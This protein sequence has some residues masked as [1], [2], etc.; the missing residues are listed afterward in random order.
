[1]GAAGAA[2]GPLIGGA[3]L[4]HFWW[5]SVFL[6]NVPIMAVVIPVVFVLLPRVEHTTPGKWAVGQ[7]LVLIAGII[8]VVY[9]IKASIGATQS[10][11][12]AMLVMA[13][14]LA[15]LVLFARQQ[16]RSATPMLD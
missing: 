2:V 6:I 10:L 8:G 12:F 9:G 3:L 7:A 11:L 5:G 13:A 16:L 1:V 4:E 15:L 14:G